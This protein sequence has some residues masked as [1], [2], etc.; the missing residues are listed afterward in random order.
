[1]R[2]YRKEHYVCKGC[3]EIVSTRLEHPYS[4]CQDWIKLLINVEIKRSTKELK[5]YQKKK[6]VRK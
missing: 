4:E 6:E 1:M 3:G 5:L 2:E